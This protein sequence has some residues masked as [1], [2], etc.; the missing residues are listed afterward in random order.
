VTNNMFPGPLPVFVVPLFWLVAVAIAALSVLASIRLLT[1]KDISEH[2]G[3]TPEPRQLAKRLRGDELDAEALAALETLTPDEQRLYGL[4]A[5]QWSPMC[6]GLGM[7]LGLAL[8]GC[9][10]AIVAKN[11]LVGFPMLVLALALNGLHFPRVQRLLAR[12]KKF[13]KDEEL[14]AFGS[15]LNDIERS[16]RVKRRKR[17]PRPT[18]RA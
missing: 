17:A 8:L 7:D 3:S 14:E 2:M 13:A 15:E 9:V 11:F 5:L 18:P 4:L 1:N 16:L 10:L 6:I 12:G